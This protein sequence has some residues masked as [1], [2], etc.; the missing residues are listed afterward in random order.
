MGCMLFVEIVLN[1]TVFLH[2]CSVRGGYKR[3][4]KEIARN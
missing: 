3:D 1:V 4:G 2:A